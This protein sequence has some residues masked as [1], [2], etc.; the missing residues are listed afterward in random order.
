MDVY[1]PEQEQALQKQSAAE[2][3][4]LPLVSA[5]NKNGVTPLAQTRE[6]RSR[7]RSPLP[8]SPTK[9]CSSPIA[10]RTSSTSTFSAAAKRAVSA[11][12]NR[13]SRPSSPRSPSTPIQDTTAELLLASRKV[14]G[15]KIPESLWPS[16]MRSLNVSFQSDKK[17][18]PA[19]Y[20]PDR[21]LRQSSNVAH[22]HAELP[23]SR[24]PTPERK[25][26]PLKSKNSSV[27]SENSKPVDSLYPRMVDQHRWPITT[28]GKVPTA[29]DDKKRPTSSLR[30]T[31]PTPSLRKTSLDRITVSS[32]SID[33][34]DMRS[35]T[36]PSPRSE[37]GT[38]SRRKLSPDSTAVLTRSN[39]VADKISKTSSLSRQETGSPPHRRLSLDGTVGPNRSIDVADK[40]SRPSSLSYGGIGAPSHRRLSLDVTAML[41]RSIGIPDKKSKSSLSPHLE[42]GTSSMKRLSPDGNAVQSRSIDL[43][44]KTSRTSS[45]FHPETITSSIRRPSLDGSPV[46][47]RSIDLVGRTTKTSSSSHTERGTPSPRIVSLDGKSKPLVKSTN[48]LLV[49]HDES[50]IALVN[51]CLVDDCSPQIVRPNSSSSSDKTKMSNAAAKHLV[52]PTLGLISTVSRWISPS[53]AKAVNSSRG[54]SPARIRPSSPTRKLQSAASVLSFITDIRHGKKAANHIEDVHN[55]RLLYNRLLQWRYANA[56]SDDAL[57][58]Q[59][60]KVERVMCSVWVEITS[61]WDSIME[62]RIEIQKLKLKLKLYSVL[63]NQICGLN[64]WALIETDHISSLTWAIEDLQASTVLVPVIRGARGNIKTIKEAVCS[65]VD[66]MQAM[67]SSLCSV[68]LKVDKMNCLV[69]ELADVVIE[70]RAM[71]DEYES[72]LISIAELQVEEYS[73][74]SHLLQMKQ[75]WSNDETTIYGY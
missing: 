47:N 41:N 22:R 74:R 44:D 48:D 12:R 60:V 15:I 52:V 2:R 38:P 64:E 42:R 67:G 59:R 35:K 39:S 71:F 13:P 43:A 23:A 28:A 70:G 7:Y 25:Q 51:G 29:L 3:T 16:T 26:T 4:R 46:P 56:Q 55:L 63:D 17:E 53:R 57:Q 49:S 5:D 14:A 37:T 1:E 32:K 65:A 19:S 69:S 68:L 62:K 54:S 21:T 66:V 6:V 10:S 36:S 50:G 73:L 58:S 8:S 20:M 18:K 33:L 11:E 24:K 45:T 75:A 72:M 30:K 34:A 61:L 40:T 9:R 31:S 27:Q